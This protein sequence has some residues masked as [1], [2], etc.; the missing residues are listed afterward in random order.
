M[1]HKL[2]VILGNKLLSPQ[3]HPE[4]IGRMDIGINLF[5]DI[6]ADYLIL[7][8]GKSNPNVKYAESEI[9]KDYAIRNN[10]S[11]EKI[12]L[13]TNSLDTVGNGYFV[14]KIVNE[15]EC[16][17]TVYIVS[18]FYHMKRVKYIFSSCFG[19]YHNLNF[20]YSYY[21]ENEEV[22]RKEERSMK[23]AKNLFRNIDYGDLEEIEKKLFSEHELYKFR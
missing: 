1:T 5:K 16:N 19:N 8:G 20:D 21:H 3:I 7:S 10:I 14:R 13:D 2:I 23:M 18:S 11:S 12:I 22:N 6:F 4:L 15:L 9:M 17:S